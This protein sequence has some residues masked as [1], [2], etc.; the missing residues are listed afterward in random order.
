MVA[1]QFFFT[2]CFL[3]FLITLTLTVLYATCWDPEQK[4]YVQI[5]ISI[6]ALLILGSICGCI[7]VIIFA[8]LG[9][10]DGWM[11]GHTNNYLGWSFALAVI[12]S[13][14]GLIAS[15][16]FLVESNIQNKKRKNLKES[17]TR[18]P[19]ESRT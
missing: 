7:S 17:Q 11:P 3:A 8:S 18:F 15:L 16:L 5:I 10:A 13:V 4:Y 12:G 6:G 2:I 1:T 14:L 9:N 19:L